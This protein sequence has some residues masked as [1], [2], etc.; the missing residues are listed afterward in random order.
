MSQ[1]QVDAANYVSPI[2]NATLILLAPLPRDGLAVG[3]KRGQIVPTQVSTL[4][5]ELSS[6]VSTI[7]LSLI[8]S[9]LFQSL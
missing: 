7:F 9:S 3:S 4:T 5:L 1:I 2:Q 8:A 6:V